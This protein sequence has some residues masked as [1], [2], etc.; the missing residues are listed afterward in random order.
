MGLEED[1]KH[2]ERA[3]KQNVADSCSARFISVPNSR[4]HTNYP[5]DEELF[6]LICLGEK[7]KKNFFFR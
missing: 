4:V 2:S 3:E 1:E 6:V 7:R 5:C